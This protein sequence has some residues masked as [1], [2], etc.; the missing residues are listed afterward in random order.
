MF[1]VEPRID[2]IVW[3]HSPVSFEHVDF[4]V[5]TQIPLKYRCPY[6][7]CVEIRLRQTLFYSTQLVVA[8]KDELI[9]PITGLKP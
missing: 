7:Y 4:G 8:V 3:A 1:T 6:Y 2:N 9:F 5:H